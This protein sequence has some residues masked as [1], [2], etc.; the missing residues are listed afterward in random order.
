MP[1]GACSRRYCSAR[2]S[3]PQKRSNRQR[4]KHT[5]RTCSSCGSPTGPTGLAMC[6]VRSWV[7][8]ECGDTHDRDV[9]RVREKRAEEGGMSTGLFWCI[10]WYHTVPAGPVGAR[11][12]SRGTRGIAC[13]AVRDVRTQCSRP[14]VYADG[15]R[16][17]SGSRHYGDHRQPLAACAAYTGAAIDLPSWSCCTPI[18][19]DA[20]AMLICY[21][22]L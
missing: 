8:S 22:C 5:P 12:K 15:R 18:R 4:E 3:R 2:A 13:H 14:T 20:I 10:V 21:A 1:A 6:A 16:L 7:C 17:R 19:H 11:P 9:R